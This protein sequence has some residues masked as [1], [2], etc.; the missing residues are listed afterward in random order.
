VVWLRVGLAAASQRAGLSGAR[1]VL[2]GN[3]RAQL[4]ALMDARAPHYAEVARLTLDTDTM[5][6]EQTV[7]A[8]CERLGLEAPA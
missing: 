7:A 8:I 3:V 1:P 2:L 5:T 6:P 4:K